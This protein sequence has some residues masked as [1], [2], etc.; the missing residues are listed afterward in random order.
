MLDCKLE[1]IPAYDPIPGLLKLG[2]EATGAEHADCAART[3]V[4]A[5]ELLAAGPHTA[6]HR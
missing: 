3:W 6:C 2:E 5:A 4:L 1:P